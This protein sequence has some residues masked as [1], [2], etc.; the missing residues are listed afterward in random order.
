MRLLAVISA[1]L[2]VVCLAMNSEDCDN[3]VGY[4]EGRNI[5]IKTTYL[6]QGAVF[7]F[8]GENSNELCEPTSPI[9]PIP[10][11]VCRAI[12]NVTTSPSSSVF[13]EIWLPSQL[14]ARLLSVGNTDFGG[15]KLCSRSAENYTYWRKGI[16]YAQMVYGLSLGFATVGSNA[17]HNSTSDG[18][19]PDQH[20]D[21]TD[22]SWR[23]VQ[24]ST[25]VGKTLI[26]KY[27]DSK[28]VKSYHL[29]CG[30][31]GRQGLRAAQADP[32]LFDG[33]AAG[34]PAVNLG[35]N[36]LWF[37]AVLDGLLQQNTSFFTQGNWEL[38][39]EEILSQCDEVDGA[40]DGIIED[41]RLCEFETL[42][43]NCL[44]VV[45]ENCLTTPQ[46]F[47]VG[48]IFKE[49]GFGVGYS[50]P[51]AAY[52][53][54]VA[55]SNILME[56]APILADVTEWFRYVSPA[57]A[58]WQPHVYDQNEAIRSL[59][60][61]PDEL[62]PLGADLKAFR[63]HGG[64]ILHWHGSAD[65]YISVLNS[66]NYYDFVLNTTS[67]GNASDID[68]FYRYFR[69]SGSEYCTGGGAGAYYVGQDGRAK[70]DKPGPEGNVLLT[71]VDWVEND[72][73]PDVLKGVRWVDDKP[74]VGV[75]LARNHCRYPYTNKYQEEG[76]DGKDE[77]KWKCEKL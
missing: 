40:K 77:E 54:E 32:E 13:T 10:V 71:L 66:D 70:P 1:S 76:G 47:V 21:L 39:H 69:I 49:L 44:I 14:E 31:G 5:Q 33:V 28:D 30:M 38:I 23:A 59:K 12:L 61:A 65:P 64:K 19:L 46:E 26:K 73:A 60:G 11:D 22:L 8:K 56:P 7:D 62:Q 29:G 67:A 16:D 51:G 74:E 37:D 17:V 63:D 2:L 43:L 9:S 35:N 36:A 72:R 52:G 68:A 57:N 41:P 45:G 25:V 53:A 24:Q 15:C 34:S 27:Y 4:A 6:P 75:E 50:N 55:L 42:A 20:E 3:L 48:Q 58:S 18:L